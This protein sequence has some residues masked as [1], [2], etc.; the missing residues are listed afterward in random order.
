MSAIASSGAVISA[1]DVGSFQR[2]VT[3]AQGKDG[4]AGLV[5]VF[6]WGQFHAPSQSGGQMDCLFSALKQRSEATFIKVNVEVCDWLHDRF[7]V[8]EVPTFLFLRDGI[9]VGRVVGVATQELAQKLQSLSTPIAEVSI[10]ARL[11]K[12]TTSA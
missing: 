1:D 7:E 10:D 8:L 12:L 6:C 4:A 5:V 3:E 9:E 2:A 11:R